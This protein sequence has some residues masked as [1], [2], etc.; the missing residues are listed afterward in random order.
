MMKQQATT[1]REMTKVINATIRITEELD[2]EEFAEYIE[3]VWTNMTNKEE[4]EKI[5][6]AVIK[7]RMV[8]I[9]DLIDI[10]GYRLYI[11][12]D[13]ELY[14]EFKTNYGGKGGEYEW[15]FNKN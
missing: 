8:K 11:I 13:P 5:V 2:D 3:G 7:D 10:D 12:E 1:N 9:N 14:N 6:K 4:A 15:Y